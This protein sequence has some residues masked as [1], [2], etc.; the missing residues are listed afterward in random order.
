MRRVQLQRPYSAE[1][2][3][4]QRAVR[5]KDYRTAALCTYPAAVPPPAAPLRSALKPCAGMTHDCNVAGT[6]PPTYTI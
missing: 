6:S 2:K 3:G 5:T 1:I 4:R